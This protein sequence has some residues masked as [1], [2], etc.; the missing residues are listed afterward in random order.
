MEKNAAHSPSSAHQS[1]RKEYFF[2]FFVLV[3]LTIVELAV[4]D[5]KSL[6]K[7]AKA[8]SLVFLAIGKAFIVAYYYMHLKDEKTWMKIIAAV[9]ISAVVYTIVL[10]L[11]ST[12]R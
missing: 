11:E 5:I 3:V 9:P 10:V 12:Y 2:I 8:S 1:H 7:M 6:S 4:P